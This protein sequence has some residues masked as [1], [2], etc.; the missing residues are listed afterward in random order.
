MNYNNIYYHLINVAKARTLNKP[1]ERHHAIPRCMGGLNIPENIVNLTPREH[2]HA[3]LLLA[4]I[5]PQHFGLITAATLMSANLTSSKVASQLRERFIEMLK[6]MP[7]TEQHKQ[8]ISEALKGRKLS[9]ELKH[10][11]SELAKTRPS[12]SEITREKLSNTMR[13]KYKSGERVH[14]M[15]GKQHTPE[16]KTKLK[17]SWNSNQFSDP[18][19]LKKA[20]ETKLKNKLNGKRYS[21]IPATEETKQLLREKALERAKLRVTCPHCG[22]EGPKANMAQYHFNKCKLAS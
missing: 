10:R 14:H 11:L 2:I 17:D 21:R 15:L 7:R 1:F 12:V 19:I 20:Q 4:K 9:S 16:T 5:Y 13:R 22:K 6:S 3:H 8:A 18:L